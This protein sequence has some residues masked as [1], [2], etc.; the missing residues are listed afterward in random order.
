MKH[1]QTS[2]GSIGLDLT[3]GP[4]MPLLLRY[5]LPILLANLLNSIYNTIDTIIIG[6]FVGST[7]IVAVTMGGKMLN[8]F[9][10]IGISFAAGGQVLI[11]QLSGAKR[12]DDLNSA[13]GTM[14][15]EMVALSAAAAATLLVFSRQILLGLN[16][17]G[18][19]FGDALAYLRITSV[20]LPL[21]FGYNA[22]SATLHGMGDSKRPL[23]FIFVAA[24]FNLI[25]DIVLVACFGLG[26]AGTAIATILGQGLSLLFSV[27]TLY[28]QRDRFCFDFKLRSLAVDWK[29]LWIM[30]KVGLPLAIRGLSIT[31]TQLLLMG[32]VNLYGLTES[33]AYSIG[34]KIYHLSTVIVVS[35]G[36]GAGGMVSQNIGA[37]RH[38]RV[39][40]IMGCTFQLSMGAAAVMALGSLCFP[41]AIFGLFTDEPEVLAYAKAFMRICCLIYVMCS[42]M[43]TYECVVTGTGNATLGFIGG[44]F[45]G[46]V[47]RVCFSFFFA[48]TLNMGITGFFM[49]EALAR[50]GPIIVGSIYYHSGAWKK[51]K[52]LI[53]S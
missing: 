7:G 27:A 15:T 53:E 32:Y 20:G 45:D 21:I 47:F 46:V 22:V 4:V 30:L 9:T 12:R 18:E 33:S 17:P 14:F 31:G 50:L 29:K 13:I 34:D 1:K 44:I 16:T 37:K 11:A 43:G 28:R 19:S 10:N 51:K 5:F 6:Q 3:T 36:Q 49:G 23:L 35:I 8:L 26:A 2:D 48:F 39:K 42:V 25:G 24:V 52:Q 41:T 40:T 38:D